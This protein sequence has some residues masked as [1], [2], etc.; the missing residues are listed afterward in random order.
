MRHAVV[1]LLR[2]FDS[3]GGQCPAAWDFA[4]EAAE[5]R[6]AH[7]S[8]SDLRWLVAEGYVELAVETTPRGRHRRFKKGCEVAIA[9]KTCVV[10]TAAGVAAARALVAN[11]ESAEAGGAEV[12]FWDRDRRELRLG[13]RIVKRFPRL[14]PLQELI[15]QAFQEQGWRRRID[16]PLP[17]GSEQVPQERLR[18]TIK[19]LNGHQ[20]CPLLRFEADGTGRGV[21]WVLFKPAGP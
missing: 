21:R 5:L 13:D 3:A 17:G 12:P 20:E 19:K 8:N 9:D 2:A 1:L 4:V 14:A 6:A 7:L 10:L 16:D 18:G 11:R 15:L